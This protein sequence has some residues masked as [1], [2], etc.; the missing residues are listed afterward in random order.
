MA[1]IVPTRFPGLHVHLDSTDSM[2]FVQVVNDALTQIGSTS[3]GSV[4]LSSIG[5]DGPVSPS[6]YKV[7][8]RSSAHRGRRTN[9]TVA[10]NEEAARWAGT[11]PG[12]GSTSA[13]EWDP[14][15]VTA[16]DGQRPAYIG[17]AHELIHARRNLLGITLDE[18]ANDEAETVGL[19][20]PPSPQVALPVTENDIRAEHGVGARTR[21][22]LETETVPHEWLYLR[23][24]F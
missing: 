17:L 22:T 1:I 12:S 19:M 3:S 18:R 2:Q 8:I 10:Q 11:R 16:E 9:R 6:G 15:V 14:N 20:R 13:I 7:V 4:L 23:G 24:L 5:N 21:Y